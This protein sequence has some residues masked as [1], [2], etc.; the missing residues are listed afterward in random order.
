MLFGYRTPETNSKL[1]KMNNERPSK[2]LS[3]FMKMTHYMCAVILSSSYLKGLSVFFNGM[4]LPFNQ[5]HS[6]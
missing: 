1:L 4:S 6:G 3:P 5:P 2:M